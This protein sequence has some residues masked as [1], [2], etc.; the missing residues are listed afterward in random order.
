MKILI[1]GNMANNLYLLA[2]SFMNYLEDIEVTF[3][4]DLY[5]GFVFG[6]SYWEDSR[7]YLKSDDFANIKIKQYKDNWE[8]P[9]W[10]KE[11]GDY[12]NTETLLTTRNDLISTIFQKK[13]NKDNLKKYNFIINEMNNHDLSI[14]CGD[15]AEYLAYYSNT[16]YIILPHGGDLMTA[17]DIKRNIKKEDFIYS[18]ML[19]KS[20]RNALFI[21]GFSP[22]VYGNFNSLEEF[23]LKY[24]YD[25]IIN[26]LTVPCEMKK[27]NINRSTLLHNLAKELND[28]KILDI[29]LAKKIIF[30]PSRIDFE[31]KKSDLLLDTIK[32]YKNNDKFYFIFSGWGNDLDKVKEKLGTELSYYIL[33]YVLSKPILYD[34]MYIAD[35]VVDQ[36]GFGTYGM[37]A[38][39]AMSVGTPVMMYIDEKAYNLSDKSAPPVLNAKNEKDI[40]QWLDKIV[41]NKID[42]GKFS[43][44]AIE[45]VEDVHNPKKNAELFY[46][47]IIMQLDKANEKY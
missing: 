43:E 33:P 5:A 8:K 23:K 37:T 29:N 36:F 47:N 14:V 25:K 18:K 38:V 1:F 21:T 10:H 11:V 16:P 26:K 19:N 20:F 22:N 44:E 24:K 2:K 15:R 42:L 17:F 40:T 45:W 32:N 7:L 12:N 9:F 3:L 31:V 34:M 46:K 39:E 13:I 4:D 28:E 35:V 27:Y 6:E 30:I 41:E